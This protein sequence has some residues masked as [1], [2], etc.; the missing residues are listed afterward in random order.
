[1]RF[2]IPASRVPLPASPSPDD[3]EI[4]QRFAQMREAD[5]EGAPGF[6]QI[7][8]RARSRQSRR[9]IQR[10][11]PLVIAAAAAVVIAT[12]WIAKAR[13]FSTHTVTPTI[14]TIAAWRA[15]TDVLLRTPG[16]ELLGMMPA[17]GASV[18]DKMISTPTNRGT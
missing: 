5:R 1:M 7:Y 14:A 3:S 13:S 8:G 15:P 4:R 10:V 16:S 9:S 2:N 18:L 6:A 11:R 17:L 12:V